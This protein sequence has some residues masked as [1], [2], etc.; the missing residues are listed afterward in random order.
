MAQ[1]T[2]LVWIR[3]PGR[4]KI[5]L[6]IAEYIFS[7]IPLRFINSPIKMNRGTATRMKLVFDS[8]ALFAMMF[9]RGA[10][11]KNHMMTR[12]RHPRAAATYSPAMKNAPI[13]PNATPNATFNT[14]SIP[15]YRGFY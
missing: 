12:E 13:R 9:Q 5:H 4:K 7:P 15:S 8:H 10:S 1:D 3:P 6:D 2:M 11:E 14:L